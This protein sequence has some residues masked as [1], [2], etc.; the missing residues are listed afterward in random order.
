MVKRKTSA[1]PAGATFSGGGFFPGIPARDLTP[2][3]WAA[4]TDKQR[5]ALTASGLYTEAA[6]I[7]EPAGESDE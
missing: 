5:A 1:A 4:L 7:E 3:E 6:V 2:E